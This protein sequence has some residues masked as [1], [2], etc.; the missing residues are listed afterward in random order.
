MDI[1]NLILST[2]TTVQ[3]SWC[4]VCRFLCLTSSELWSRPPAH[5]F[6]PEAAGAAGG[7]AAGGNTDRDGEQSGKTGQRQNCR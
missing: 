6:Q 4:H 5:I 2:W 3:E 1:T 7:A